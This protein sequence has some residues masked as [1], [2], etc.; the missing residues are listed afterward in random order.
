MTNINQLKFQTLSEAWAGINEFLLVEENKIIA[1]GGGIY[2]VEFVSYDNYITINRAWVDPEFD[3]GKTLGYN[4]KKWSMLVN[5]YVD[6]R[7]LD[8]I[9][10]EVAMRL[11]KNTNHY[12]YTYH[13]VNFHGSGKD[14]L[15]SLTFMKRISSDYPT[16]LFTVR[17]SEV[18]KRLIWDFLLVERI[19]E[20]VYGNTEA[21]VIFV[22]PSMFITQ[23]SV[24]IY[25]NYHSIDDIIATVPENKRTRFQRAVLKKLH[26]FKNHPDPAS[27]KFKVHRRSAMQICRDEHGEPLSGVVSLKAKELVLKQMKN[28]PKNIITKRQQKLYDQGISEY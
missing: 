11:K 17:T 3:F 2:G 19:I 4:K 6:F 26:Q 18:T 22:A 27:I 15:I 12:N 28:Y 20:Y 25:D 1:R 21:E 14:C 16:V 10:G 8:M 9:R 23:E 7:Y 24:L 13:F 5:N